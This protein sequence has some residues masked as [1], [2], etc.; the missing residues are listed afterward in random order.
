M[1]PSVDESKLSYGPSGGLTKNGEFVLEG[2]I[3]PNDGTPSA[4]IRGIYTKKEDGSVVKE[5]LM[6]DE[7]QNLWNQVFIG[8]AKKAQ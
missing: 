6:F 5:F 3:Y 7:K 2:M 1:A 8:V 4:K